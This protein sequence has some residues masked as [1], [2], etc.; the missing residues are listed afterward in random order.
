[1]EKYL[2]LKQNIW[3][4]RNV[5]KKNKEMKEKEEEDREEDA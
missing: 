2:R 5:E 3:M 4:E 1:M